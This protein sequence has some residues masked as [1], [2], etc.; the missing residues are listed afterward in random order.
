M[1]LCDQSLLAIS[2][3][4]NA[5][6]AMTAAV[7][8]ATFCVVVGVSETAHLEEANDET[9]KT[10]H[11]PSM[12][13]KDA[14]KEDTKEF[15]TSTA[16]QTFLKGI[17]SGAQE[18]KKPFMDQIGN[19]VGSIKDEVV[20]MLQFKGSGTKGEEGGGLFGLVDSVTSIIK[21]GDDREDAL[22][23]LMSSARNAAQSGG[24]QDTA[25]FSELLSLME[26][27][28]DKI[29]PILKDHFGHIDFSY[30]TP[31]SLWYYLEYEDE[32]KNPSWKRVQ[33]RFHKGID[34][35]TVEDLNDALMLADL[36]YAD[37]PEELK[38][39]LKTAN[40]PLELVYYHMDSEPGKPS[41]FI[42]VK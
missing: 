10:S 15:W 8:T 12:V 24:I 9:N 17:I 2:R 21:G 38:E 31:T 34:V 11:K 13:R 4:S 37:S 36:S 42:A 26:I 39:G 27:V 19:K 5:F 20:S 1:W 28:S 3:R 41:H 40:I 35:R 29:E 14:K 30:F 25:G 22:D 16:G 6:T 33:H 7:A 23:A 18:A 32:V